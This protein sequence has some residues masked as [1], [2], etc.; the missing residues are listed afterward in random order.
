MGF[1]SLNP[2]YDSP[3]YTLR[4]S[5][6]IEINPLPNQTFYHCFQLK[7]RWVGGVLRR[8][9]VKPQ[10]RSNVYVTGTTRASL[11][12]CRPLAGGEE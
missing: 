6:L 8:R 9:L 3:L 12:P 10:R 4:H 1:A 7:I 2:S 11:S 5:A